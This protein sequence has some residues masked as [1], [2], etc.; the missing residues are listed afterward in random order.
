LCIGDLI[1]IPILSMLYH[2]CCLLCR[3]SLILYMFS[4]AFLAGIELFYYE[5]VFWIFCFTILV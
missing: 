1:W 2:F 3:F 5:Q 4:G